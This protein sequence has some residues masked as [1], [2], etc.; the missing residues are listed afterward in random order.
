MEKNENKVMM[1]TMMFL[2]AA[3]PKELIVKRLL[4]SCKKY[5]ETKAKEDETELDFNVML[6]GMKAATGGSMKEA[7]NMMNEMEKVRNLR[8]IIAHQKEN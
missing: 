3:M 8:D 7:V 2:S 1:E 6:L 5:L 4:E